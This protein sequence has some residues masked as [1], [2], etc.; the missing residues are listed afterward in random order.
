MSQ[1]DDPTVLPSQLALAGT[2]VLHR[3]C[4]SY[5]Q[6]IWPP[7]RLGRL[8]DIL[9]LT[10]TTSRGVGI[11][12][13][14]IGVDLRMIV[15]GDRAVAPP[16]VD[17]GLYGRQ[18]RYPFETYG[19]LDPVLEPVLDAGW[20]AW[21]EGCLSVPGYTALVARWNAVVVRALTPAGEPTTFQADGWHARIL[22]HETDHVNGVLYTE[23]MTPRTLMDKARYQTHWQGLPV[24][25]VLTGL[26]AEVLVPPG[27]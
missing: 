23:R 11:A 24:A 2:P 15:L 19:L 4:R 5:D 27:S 25:D 9:S 8:R 14:Q 20:S 21:F 3:V 18:G 10:M 6:E 16:G 12:A 22:Q 26:G 13:N 1:P 7:D 17:P